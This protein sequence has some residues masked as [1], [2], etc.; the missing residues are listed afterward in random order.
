MMPTVLFLTAQQDTIDMLPY[1][2]IVVPDDTWIDKSFGN[3]EIIRSDMTIINKRNPSQSFKIDIKHYE[4]ESAK[5]WATERF[6]K[7]YG[8]DR[9]KEVEA[10]VEFN[11]LRPDLIELVL[12]MKPS[13]CADERD[14]MLEILGDGIEIHFFI[15][16]LGNHRLL[17]IEPD[18]QIF[19]VQNFEEITPIEKEIA[20]NSIILTPAMADSIASLPI[21]GELLK[22]TWQDIQSDTSKAS[23]D[24]LIRKMYCLTP[25]AIRDE[26][27]SAYGKSITDSLY[28]LNKPEIIEKYYTQL[29]NGEEKARKFGPMLSKYILN[30]SYQEHLNLKIKDEQK[31]YPL[32][33]YLSSIYGI[34]S[35]ND[36]CRLTTLNELDNQFRHSFPIAIE[37]NQFILPDQELVDP[38]IGEFE[39]IQF[40]EKTFYK[41]LERTFMKDSSHV[42]IE[43]HNRILNG[44]WMT[45]ETTKSEN[46]HILFKYNDGTWTHQEMAFPAASGPNEIW[47]ISELSTPTLTVFKKADMQHFFLK[48]T[49]DTKNI[50]VEI[51][52]IVFD[53]SSYIMISSAHKKYYDDYSKEEILYSTLKKRGQF[54]AFVK[55][56]LPD[57]KTKSEVDAIVSDY[58]NNY[59][60][61]V[62]PDVFLSSYTIESVLED[63]LKPADKIRI[64][65]LDIQDLDNDSLPEIYQYALSNGKIISLDMYRETPQGIIKVKK[66]EAQKLLMKN[67]DFR[68]NLINSLRGNFEG[69]KFLKEE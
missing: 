68:D 12:K 64:F 6:E 66:S 57:A 28:L 50:W 39:G 61:E 7:R 55:H 56:L 3:G 25:E 34:V 10:Q 27:S 13:E 23:S 2:R 67:N 22:K 52:P 30:Y 16:E 1:A 43:N 42:I 48:N 29:K 38:L 62:K 54:E 44:I 11:E 17:S 5:A 46:L 58:E 24:A 65:D 63:E 20:L 14:K 69:Y 49:A 53:S 47:T 51:K 37:N 40:D 60:I 9:N 32:E 36:M 45:L 31:V 59:W 18:D 26:L 41:V 21:S 33:D 4:K 19:N 35:N 15:I 8:D